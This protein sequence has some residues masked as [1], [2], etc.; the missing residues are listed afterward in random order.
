ILKTTRVVCEFQLDTNS[1]ASNRISVKWR[2][3]ERNDGGLIQIVYSGNPEVPFTLDG[4]IVGQHSPFEVARSFEQQ[5][6]IFPLR[7]VSWLLP[8]FAII[9]QTAASIY[10]IV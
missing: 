10:L 6:R 3:L 4:V 5:G 8:L 2:I 7:V 1:T 9:L